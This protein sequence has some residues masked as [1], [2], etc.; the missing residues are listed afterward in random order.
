MKSILVK[1]GYEGSVKIISNGRVT[2]LY[3]QGHAE[4]WIRQFP[5]SISIRPKKMDAEVHLCRGDWFLPGMVP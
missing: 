1:C 2:H 3:C 5:G 4:D